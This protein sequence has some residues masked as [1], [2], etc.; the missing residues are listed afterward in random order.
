M[1]LKKPVLQSWISKCSENIYYGV[2]CWCK[3]VTFDHVNPK[4]SYKRSFKWFVLLEIIWDLAFAYSN[5]MNIIH[6][7]SLWSHLT[8]LK[9]IFKHDFDI[10]EVLGSHAQKCMTTVCYFAAKL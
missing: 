9:P 4:T 2:I 5:L 3:C 8:K 1:T 10:S 6:R 7:K